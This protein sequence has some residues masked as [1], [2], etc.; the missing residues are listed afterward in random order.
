[1]TSGRMTG[2]LDYA[3]VHRAIE[4]IDRKGPTLRHV[5]E[6]NP[7]ALTIA[8][9]LDR[10]RKSDECV[11]HCTAFRFCSRTTSTPRIG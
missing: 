10:E 2:A 8:D 11:D 4:E 5:L 7:D 3:A 9:S 6:I 1:M